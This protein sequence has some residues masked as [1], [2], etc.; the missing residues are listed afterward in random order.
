MICIYGAGPGKD[1]VARLL[2]EELEKG[3]KRVLITYFAA[4]LRQICRNWFGWNGQNDDAGRSTLQYVGTEIVRA[5]RPDFWVDYTMGLLSIMGDEWDFVIV[6]DCRWPN[7]LDLER[8]GFQTRRIRV[9]GRYPL[10]G[11]LNKIA[12]DFTVTS[13]S[14]P[15]RLCDTIATVAQR[16]LYG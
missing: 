11:P 4:P 9:E 6:P 1:A 10:D 8:Y 5:K 2:K 12:P 14:V 15:V 7:E 16:L 3:E 13:D